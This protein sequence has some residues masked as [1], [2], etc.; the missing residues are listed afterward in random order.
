MRLFKNDFK[1]AG[2]KNAGGSNLERQI[3]TD[4]K[5]FGV[6]QKRQFQTEE[7]VKEISLM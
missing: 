7:E 5:K 6:R 1:S 4:K 3:K 2:K